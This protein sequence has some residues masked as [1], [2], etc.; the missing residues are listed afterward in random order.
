MVK[1]INYNNNR[2]HGAAG[3]GVGAK[4]RGSGNQRRQNKKFK[5]HP[6][7][8]HLLYMILIE[9]FVL[10]ITPKTEFVEVRP[11]T[12]FNRSRDTSENKMN[13]MNHVLKMN[14]DASAQKA[15][16]KQ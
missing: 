10:P 4:R 8:N 5:F 7:R 1:K 11:K 12:M 6:P 14:L 15:P 3:G 13:Q 9:L 16:Q 2:L